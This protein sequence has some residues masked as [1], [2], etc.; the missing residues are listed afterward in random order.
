M[1]SNCAKAYLTRTTRLPARLPSVVR[2][3]SGVNRKRMLPDSWPLMFRYARVTSKLLKPC[4]FSSS[5]SY[6]K[7]DSTPTRTIGYCGGAGVWA[8][9]GVGAGAWAAA[10][11]TERTTRAKAASALVVILPLLVRHTDFTQVTRSLHV[12]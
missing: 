6:W 2:R 10:L 4:L 1:L 9:G 8:G 5:A 7:Y 11:L 12:G 3:M